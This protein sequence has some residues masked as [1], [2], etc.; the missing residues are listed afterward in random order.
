MNTVKKQRNEFPVFGD[1]MANIFDDPFFANT[2]KS[3]DTPKVNIIEG[4]EN[5][6]IQL[7]SPGM[8]KDQFSIDLKENILI[9]GA[10]ERKEE[11]KENERFTLQEFKYNEFQRKF[12]LPKNANTESIKA[13]YFDGILEV[14]IAKLIHKE[15]EAKKIVIS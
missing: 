5:Y 4:K 3:R 1:V 11:S 7:A 6:K 14:S 13:S 12:K 15:K 8:H 9:I 2:Q 10:K